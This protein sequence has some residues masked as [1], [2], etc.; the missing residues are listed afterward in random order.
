MIVCGLWQ[1]MMLLVVYINGICVTVSDVCASDN[2][3]NFIIVVD[4]RDIL[5]CQFCD[6]IFEAVYLLET[7]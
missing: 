5:N 1:N 6:I 2:D 3:F 4:G 7:V